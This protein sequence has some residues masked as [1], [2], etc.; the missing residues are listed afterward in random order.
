MA[1]M[2]DFRKIE[3]KWQERW[4]GE[5]AF[6]P[7]IDHKKKKV[8]LTVPYPYT[9]GPLHI[10]HGRTNTLADIW[11]RHRRMLGF[12]VLW[13][14]AFHISGTPIEAVSR[15]LADG[16]K[17]TIELY[18]EYVGLYEDDKRKIEKTVESFKDPWNVARY[19][20]N[21]I[22]NDF[23]ALGFSI[24]WSRQFTTGDPEYN[25][26]IAWQF[27]RLKQLGLITKG[28]HPV[29]Y[30]L[31]CNNAV[32]E[33]DIQ[34]G[35]R[36]DTGIKAFTAVKFPFEDGFL[37]AATLRPE[38]IH[39]VTNIWI[40]PSGEYV[41]ARVGNE[42]YYVSG[43]AAEKM[44][45]QADNVKVISAIKPHDLLGKRAKS[46]VESR[47]LP[48]LPAAFVD[49]GNG[50]GIVYS[51]PAHAPAD[52]MALEELKKD[53]HWE[54]EAKHIRPISV[55]RLDGYGDCPAKE[56]IERSGANAAAEERIGTATSRL[57]KEEFYN[58]TLKVGRFSGVAIKD[59]KN[60]VKD[61]L[62]ME[63][64]ALDFFESETPG[65]LCRDG[66]RVVVKTIKDQWFIDYGNAQWKEK[67]AK[68][69][70]KMKLIPAEYRGHFEHT[71]GW[72]HERAAARKRGL[73]TR[74]PWDTGWVI[75]S[76]SDST[77]YPAFYTAVKGIRESRLKENEL[78]SEFFDYIFLGKGS[79]RKGESIRKEFE[80]WYPVDLRHTAVAHVTNHLTFYIFNHAAIFPEKYW[81]KAI[82]LNE[83]LVREGA[84]MSKSRGNVIPLADISEKY[85]ADL[86]RLYISSGADLD[87]V[88]DW[89]EEGVKMA[90]RRLARFFE[91]ASGIIRHGPKKTE[92][93]HLERWLVSR[94]NRTLKET[95]G[96]LDGF[97]IREF[98][99][100]AFFEVM[101][102]FGHYLRRAEKPHYAVL[103][104]LLGDWIKALSP[105]I[106]HVCEELWEMS[107][108]GSLVSLEEWPKG[109]ENL[110][111]EPAERAEEL[112]IRTASDIHEIARI[113]GRKPQEIKVYTSL[114]W[115]YKAYM[116]AK[117]MA[118]RKDLLKAL[119]K[120]EDIK[121]YGQAAVR[122]AESLKKTD[123]SK[124]MLDKEGE[125]K[126]L[127]SAEHFLSMEF[128]CAVSVSMAEESGSEKALRA[129]PGKPGIEII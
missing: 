29:Q 76:L 102:D 119:M 68:C 37:V 100:R 115:K 34:D 18:K 111:C 128:G 72:L 75:E 43:Y 9:S 66:G 62:K 49:P 10:G 110:I 97:R 6:E 89:T 116:E 12:N 55:I 82:S 2:F 42:I 45:H 8:F 20:A 93:T 85:G 25:R 39:G 57:Y 124:E 118:D 67:A 32:G 24:D 113:V 36:L 64:K 56:A 129:E 88:I 47:G 94:F 65:L 63:G 21:V 98:S 127:K 90:Q 53:R 27:G 109:N 19:F 69:L 59:I 80:Y 48:I 78:T 77:I 7:H 108:G 84:K 58:G 16:D 3:K 95:E 114:P 87:S 41:K 71:I 101:N 83:L 121:R 79:M 73:G 22:I 28:D 104:N 33:D 46:P 105:L 60:K 99:Q 31:K 61:W 74:L 91:M 81:P 1:A 26:F 107:G 23:R 117:G 17:K 125:F 126:A 30:C 15:K 103:N 112:V 4:E 38:T 14:M 86:Y 13:P 54:K 51:V 44:Q 40:N 96:L 70:A 120:H 50:T 5:K 122:Y 52:Y 123:F 35:D 106:P 11:A 92:E